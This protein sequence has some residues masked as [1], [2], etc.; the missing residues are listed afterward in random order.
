MD[1]KQFDNII[2]DKLENQPL[3]TFD[4]AALAD[5]KLRMAADMVTPWYITYRYALITAAAVVVILL[6]NGG[7]F[8][9]MWQN[10][11]EWVENNTTPS[12]NM[13]AHTPL[14][15]TIYVSD[16]SYKDELSALKKKIDDLLQ[17][18]GESVNALNRAGLL[19]E[20]YQNRA[21]QLAS[22]LSQL[23]NQVVSNSIDTVYVS[24]PDDDRLVALQE[25]LRKVYD[26]ID[27]LSNEA[28]TVD[29]KEDDLVRLGAVSQLSEDILKK[30]EDYNLIV[31][32]GE[33]VYLK[34]NDRFIPLLY[35]QR[36]TKSGEDV[37]VLVPLS[38]ENEQIVAELTTN[39]GLI[40][41]KAGLLP[42]KMQREL[43]KHYTKGVGIKVGPSIGVNKPFFD[44]G[45]GDIRPLYGMKADFIMSPSI[46]IETGF[47]YTQIIN[48]I[49][50]EVNLSR[51]AKP[52][53]DPTRGD[54]IAMEV[55]SEFI[56][57]PLS[58][59]Y[60]YPI[61]EGT[62]F[63]SLG[64]SSVFYSSQVF[65]YDQSFETG[66]QTLGVS[67]GANFIPSAQY[68]NYANISLGITQL[69]KKQ[70]S[71]ELAIIYQQGLQDM[72]ESDFK[73]SLL[74]LRTAYWF[75]IR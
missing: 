37:L 36:G 33:D 32:K 39:E 29:F 48:E 15:D 61:S 26:K 21:K 4:P 31:T 53:F 20:L 38:A 19:A 69:V 64:V 55:E 12:N 14:I 35:K 70:N 25:E 17:I 62:V 41:D 65:D 66:S 50:G 1:D 67:S 60:R 22:E 42:V 56:E 57:V 75:K 47:N 45:K 73:N 2:K 11:P 8:Y 63:G 18:N 51:V 24:G 52:Q 27:S 16:Q 74:G 44:V 7:L 71:F 9:Y 23:Q 13:L 40:K 46:S 54:L 5:L 59:K 3:E 30:L 43:E 68:M 10:Q 6:F 34:P 49:E 58:V 28:N 72:G